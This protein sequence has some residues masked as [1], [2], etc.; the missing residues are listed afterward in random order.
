[1]MDIDTK[2]ANELRRIDN[3]IGQSFEQVDDDGNLQDLTDA[4]MAK[5]CQ[6]G[7]RGEFE[8]PQIMTENFPTGGGSLKVIRYGPIS[9]LGTKR[10]E[11]V[12]KLIAAKGSHT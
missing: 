4:E 11:N 6:I 10:A 1:M 12:K 5:A 8:V 3:E 7:H 2:I 9:W